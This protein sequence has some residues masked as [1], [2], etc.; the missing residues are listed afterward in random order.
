MKKW[1]KADEKVGKSG[2]KCGTKRMKKWDKA[3]EKVGQSG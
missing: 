2:R 3:D 1:D